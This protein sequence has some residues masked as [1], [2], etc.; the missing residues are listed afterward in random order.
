MLD[1]LT[2]HPRFCGSSRGRAR[3][4]ERHGLPS[5]LSSER[6]HHC[7]NYLLVFASFHCVVVST[8]CTAWHLLTKGFYEKAARPTCFLSRRPPNL[9]CHIPFL[10]PSSQQSCH[11]LGIDPFMTFTATSQGSTP[12]GFSLCAKKSRGQNSN[13][14]LTHPNTTNLDPKAVC[15]MIEHSSSWAS[16]L[17][18]LY[19]MCWVGQSLVDLGLTNVECEPGGKTPHAHEIVNVFKAQ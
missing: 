7:V 18:I 11:N 13:Q 16:K 6:W 2:E 15:L 19:Y 4:W 3:M 10:L 8:R 14:I 12:Q 17:L 9:H 1:W 5:A